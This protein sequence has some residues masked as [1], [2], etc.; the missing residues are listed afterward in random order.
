MEPQTK[1]L[2]GGMLPCGCRTDNSIFILLSGPRLWASF[3]SARYRK[4]LFSFRAKKALVLTC[5][6]I[7]LE[8]HETLAKERT[9]KCLR[10]M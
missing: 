9:Q 3:F 8:W 6:F 4:I 10:K 2:I 1:A 7:Y 5:S